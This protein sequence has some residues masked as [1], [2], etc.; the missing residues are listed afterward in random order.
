MRLANVMLPPQASRNHSV[1]V[2][3][4]T[5]YLNRTTTQPIGMLYVGEGTLWFSTLISLTVSR[6]AD[7]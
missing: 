7:R 6:S 4:Q 1:S 2:S 5:E 3:L